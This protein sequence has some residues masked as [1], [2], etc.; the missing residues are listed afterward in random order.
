[1]YIF[2]LLFACSSSEPA[3]VQ[4]K[5]KPAQP[6][7]SLLLSDVTIQAGTT[8]PSAKGYFSVDLNGDGT[9]EQ[10][11]FDESGIRTPTGL[12][13]LEGSLQAAIRIDP[14]QD[15]KEELIIALGSGKGF[16][17]A[18][19]QLLSLNQEGIVPLWKESKGNNQIPDIQAFNNNIFF[20]HSTEDAAF[21]GSFFDM[22]TKTIRTLATSKLALRMLPKDESSVYVGRVYGEEPRSD[23]DLRVFQDGEAQKTIQAFRGIR[24][25]CLSDINQDKNK[26]LLVS[27]GWHYQYGTMARARVSLFT[28]DESQAIPL[29]DLPNEYTINRIEPHRDYPNLFLLEA[30][31]GA[32]ILYQ[33]EYGWKTTKVC[34]FA[35]G[36]NAVFSY[37]KKTYSVLCSGRKSAQ[38]PF[39]ITKQQ[40]N[41]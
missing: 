9:D 11:Y 38:Y 13:P 22:Q 24:A 30:S 14:N 34:S 29:S 8:I 19:M 5:E 7:A 28:T 4:A 21:S 23:G 12:I 10:I 18:P 32:Y 20:V 25:L 16:R 6:I 3:S 39:V 31:R 35:E 40:G 27:D 26:E 37:H 17:D 41:H 36:D 2:F 1:M 15:G 33:T